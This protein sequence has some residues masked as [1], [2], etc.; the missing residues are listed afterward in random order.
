MDKTKLIDK[1]NQAIGLELTGL[2][3]YNQ[4]AHVLLGEDRKIWADY[5]KGAS[6][7]SLAHARKFASRVV[8]LGGTP[9][10]EPEPVHQ[11]QDVQEMLRLSLDH[12]RKAV[13]IYSDAL[14]LCENNAA[15][16]NILEEQ[17]SMETE[18]VEELEKYLNQVQKVAAG[19]S[20]KRHVKTA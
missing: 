5:F 18:D 19:T 6:D 8:A 7:E 4:Y 15:Y 13:G 11:T 3:Q 17:I 1:L 2:L 14:A 10:V 16:R 20:G 12:E 9:N